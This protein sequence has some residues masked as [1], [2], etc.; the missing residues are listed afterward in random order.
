MTEL[1]HHRESPAAPRLAEGLELIGE[2]K[3]SALEE[4]PYLVRRADGQVIQMSRLL[5][6]V[7]EAAD[8][9]RD[10]AQIAER[11]SEEFGRLVSAE[12]VR[13]LVEEKLD[14]LGV[15]AQDNDDGST[16]EELERSTPLLGVRFRLGLVPEGVV[17]RLTVPFLP[18]FWP[19]VVLAVLCGLLALDVWLVFVHGVGQGVRDVSNQPSLVLA[20]FLLEMGAMAWHELGHATA[21]RY[22]G[23]KPGKVGV[24]IY[25]VWFV[26]FSD[27]T[28]SYRLDKVGRLR[29]D[30][31]GLYFDAILTLGLA[32]AYFLTG[33]EPLLAVALFNQLASLD[34]LSPFLRFDGYYIVS[35]LTGVPDL[36]RYIKPVARSLIPGQEADESLKELKPWVRVVL[37]VWVLSVVPVLLLGLGMLAYHGPWVIAATWDSFFVHYGEVSAAFGEG[38]TIDGLVGLVDVVTL[39]VPVVGGI[40]LFAWALGR[41]VVVTWRRSRGRPLLRTGFLVAPVA[42]AGLVLL[43]WWPSLGPL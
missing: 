17:S 10:F 27:V 26:F 1:L 34:E 43:V 42:T 2:Y 20:F 36:F 21:C 8:G 14:P 18:L 3:G 31:G 19:P 35:D 7:A 11:V 40:V 29:T 22:G 6:L 16:P 15:L 37:T 9:R 25:I 38:R 30:C 12:N 4:P 28:D 32:G 13:F 33:F 5:Y 39:V 24:G 41:L 23:A